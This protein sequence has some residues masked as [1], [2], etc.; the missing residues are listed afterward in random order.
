MAASISTPRAQRRSTAPDGT[1]RD[2]AVA[3]SDGPERRAASEGSGT[4][5]V[6]KSQLQLLALVGRLK[7]RTQNLRLHSARPQ[8]TLHG[9]SGTA[10]CSE[11][12]CTARP[13]PVVS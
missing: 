10:G 2:K 9:G 4:Y 12:S 7:S 3:A 5:V 1:G 11:R 6:I 8:V 13:T